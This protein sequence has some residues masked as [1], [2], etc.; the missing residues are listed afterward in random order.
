MHLRRCFLTTFVFLYCVSFLPAQEQPGATD[1]QQIEQTLTAQA[2]AWNKGDLEGFMAG[3]AKI[4]TLRFATGNTVT[5]GWQETL[6]RYKE[7][8]PDR[9]AM[10]AL[11]FSDLDITMLSPESALVFGRWRLKRDD[12]EPSGLFTLLWRKTD[13][14][15]RIVADHTS[16][17][18]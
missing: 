1:K 10:G 9:S 4:P 3:Y 13:A 18:S 6:D 16:A 7:R 8:Y 12:G 17:G 15:W 2:A 5:Y 11:T 14:G